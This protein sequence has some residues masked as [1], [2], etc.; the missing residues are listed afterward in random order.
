MVRTFQLVVLTILLFSVLASGQASAPSAA[1]TT[2][3][4]NQ[5][6]PAFHVRAAVDAYL[7][8]MP[9]AQRARSDAYFEGGYWLQ[10]WDFLITVFVMWLLLR[11]GWSAR[12]RDLAERISRIPHHQTAIYWVQFIVVV[13]VLTFPMSLYEGY[14]REHKYG[15]LNQ[16]FGPWMRDQMVGLGVSVVLGAILVV[17]LFALVRRLGKSWWVWGAIVMI[18]FV[19]LVSLIA[20]VYIAPL[21]NKYNADRPT[22][23][24]PDSEHG[25]GER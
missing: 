3:T 15:L 13:T 25:A 9:P 12:M 14:F 24:R 6:G 17:P 20:P 5:A 19:A 4:A 7:A 18:A 22:N 2:Q 21:F 16:T 23:Q 1:S 10:L 11:F 8:K